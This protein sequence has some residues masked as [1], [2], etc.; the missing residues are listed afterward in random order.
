M[1]WLRTRPPAS[2]TALSSGSSRP[3]KP[4]ATL[5]KTFLAIRM[6]RVAAADAARIEGIE[7]ELSVI[8]LG[9]SRSVINE[10]VPAIRELLAAEAVAIMSPAE[11]LGGG[12]TFSRLSISGFPDSFGL[13]FERFINRAPRRYGSFDPVCPEHFDPALECRSVGLAD[14]TLD[15]TKADA[16]EPV[17]FDHGV[18]LARSYFPATVEAGANLPVWLWWQFDAARGETDT[19]FI[20]VTD[21]AGELVGQ[22]DIPLGAILA[23]ETRAEAVE[24][25]LPGVDPE[26]VDLDVERNV[27]TVKAERPSRAGDAEML[28]AERPRGVFSRQLVLGD[29]LDT[30]HI[31]ASYDAGVLSLQIP[32]AEQAKPRKIAIASKG[33]DRRAINA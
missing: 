13:A 18:T 7:H 24:I 30:E 3:T 12:L 27:V 10:V 20:H 28:A 1:P 21:A 33:D 6:A 26:S 8:C 9:R 17:S 14:A 31:T 23:G 5:R 22:Q 11:R 25:D 4:F 29:N 16:T 19:R 32:V 15:Y 2:S